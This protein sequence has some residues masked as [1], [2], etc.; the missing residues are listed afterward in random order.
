M[1]GKLN[2]N[3]NNLVYS[4]TDLFNC[5]KNSVYK[6]QDIAYRIIQ[7][8]IRNQSLEAMFQLTD[9]LSADRMLDKLHRVNQAGVRQ[10][11]KKCN[12]KLRLPR[13]VTLA[14]DFTDKPYYGDKNHFE[15]VGSKGGKYVRRYIELS[16]VK[17]ALFI[18][19]LPVNQ[20]SNDKE[21]LLRVLLGKFHEEYV[22]TIIKLLLADRGFFTKKV[23]KLLVE[24]STPFIMP[25]V[26]NERVKKFIKAFEEKEIKSR[27]KYEFGD[28]TVN[29]LFIKLKNKKTQKD[30]VY[31]YITNTNKTPLQAYMLYKKRWQIETNFRE[32]NKFTFK[33][34]TKDFNIRYLA[35]VIG[36]LLLNAWQLTRRLVPYILQNYL[37]KEYLKD[38]LLRQW[39]EISKRSVIKNINYFLVA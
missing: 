13:R 2:L 32:Q 30:E 29:L 37:Y 7:S 19:A 15:V 18:N 11:I 26:K 16:V 38:E 4:L 39:S 31:A 33:T 36:G 27:V 5:G 17:P 22:K 6:A 3:I 35:F 34:A 25:A 28:V 12:E 1:T 21:K 8:G 23:V 10:L 14:I 24:S 9:Y 20:L